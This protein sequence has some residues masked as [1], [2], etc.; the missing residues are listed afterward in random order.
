MRTKYLLVAIVLLFLFTRLY[1]ITEIPVSLY[2]DEASIGYNAH[3]VL[4]T[5]KDEWGEFLPLHF[6]AFGEFKLPV[7]IYSVA[8]TELFVGFNPLAVRLPVVLFS[9]GVV[10]LTFL[11]T[12][13]ITSKNSTSLYAAFLFSICP[14]TFIFSR[15]GYEAMAGLMFYLLAI[16]LLM[17]LNRHK[18]F[19]FLSAIS[20]IL[21]MFSYN[22]FRLISPL[23]MV[24]LWVYSAWIW[25]IFAKKYLFVGIA[26]LSVCFL[27]LIPIWR[28]ISL[29]NGLSRLQVV[30]LNTSDGR[31]GS[32]INFSKN[33]LVHFDPMFLFIK[34]DPNLRSNLGDQGQIYIAEFLLIIVG[35][36]SV[37]KSK[38]K[39]LFLPLLIIL[40]SPLPAAMTKEAP[41]ALRAV[42]AVPFLSI[43]AAIGLT[44]IIDLKKLR[45]KKELWLF[46]IILPLILFAN[47]LNNFFTIY[48]AKSS[49]D[50]HYGYK[51]I[52]TQY[53][54]KFKSFDKVI[55]SDQYAQPY[56]FALYYQK[57]DPNT[58]RSS[59][60]Y[61][62][63]DN[64]GFSTVNRIGNMEFIKIKGLGS[65]PKG[66]LLV[67]SSILD[68]IEADPVA[69]IKNLD[70]TIAFYV[71]EVDK[72]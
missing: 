62:S 1:K 48:P 26:S 27:S 44:A 49:K 5:G 43:L 36:I 69:H 31:M 7:Y 64:W 41:H 54:D 63:P 18:I 51:Q 30:S 53:Q 39:I 42:S 19:I 9:L 47:Y 65:L 67:F 56:I 40:F 4:T 34:G 68:Q 22:S 23:T 45:F 38:K 66:K 72:K 21:S 71:Y 29:D 55:I 28:L 61:N 3:S 25:K 50:W 8:V 32:F 35:L 11:I 58:F 33:Y 57:T 2:W 59:M 14:W 52:F 12:L 46:A 24:V 13:K 6:R 37:L 10:I 16:Y 15:T 20:F 70:G 17:L 60:S